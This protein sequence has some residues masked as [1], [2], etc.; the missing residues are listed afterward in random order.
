MAFVGYAQPPE[1]LNVQPQKPARDQLAEYR[2][3]LLLAQLRADAVGG[4]AVVPEFADFLG[5]GAAQQ[6][7]DMGGA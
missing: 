6:V 7:D 4:Q 2:V 3:P 1:A 5:L